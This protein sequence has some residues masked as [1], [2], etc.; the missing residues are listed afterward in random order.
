MDARTFDR[1]TA[2]IARRNALRLLAGGALAGLLSPRLTRAA[3][4]SDMDGDG[5]FDDDETLVHGTDPF[6]ADTD[7]DLL[8]D[9]QE[10]VLGTDPRDPASPGAGGDIDGD[11]LTD[12]DEVNIHGTNMNSPDSDQDGASDGAEVVAG[13]NPLVA[14]EAD[15]DGNVGCPAGSGL[16]YC[17]EVFG[18]VDLRFDTSNCGACGIAC[19]AG[20]TCQGATCA[21]TRPVPP[22]C[23]EADIFGN[24]V[25]MSRDEDGRCIPPA[26]DPIT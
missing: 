6:A 21:A 22:G 3:Q 9:R 18:C 25:C 8:D 2:A 16:T 19:A 26:S 15:S 23:S 10:I 20:E 11:G 17:G 1:W 24:C 7:G 14:Q 12:A 5:L 4:N 13:T